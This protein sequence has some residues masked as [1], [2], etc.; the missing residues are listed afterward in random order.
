MK[1]RSTEPEP[2]A[3]KKVVV[4]GLARQGMALARYLV[5]EGA[6]VTISDLRDAE[7]LR[8]ALGSLSDIP[9]H[10]V[11]GEHPFS[12]LSDADLVCLSG[13]VPVH[14]PIV[15]E[16]QRRGI[17]LSNDAQLFLERCSA[18]VV[19]ITGSSGKT[20][21]TALVGRMLQRD[22]FLTWVGGNIGRPLVDRL[23]EIREEDRVVM[24][25]SSFQL[26]VMSV[27][28]EVAAVLNVTPNHLDRH[29]TMA[30]YTAIK[31][32][33]LDFQG[34]NGLA[35]L[36]EDDEGSRR[37]ATA[38]RGRLA[39]F[40][41]QNQTTDDINANTGAYIR[42]RKLTVRLGDRE[43]AICLTDEVKLL[44]RHNLQNVLAACVLAA[45]VGVSIDVMRDV[46]TSFTGVEHRLQFVRTLNGVRYYDDSIATAPE[47]TVAALRAFDVPVVLLAGG[48][49]KS[50]PWDEMAQITL[51]RARHVV[52]FGEAAQ[53]VESEIHKA[54]R[55]Q[56]GAT[57]E[58]LT[59]VGT[60]EEAVDVA[61]RVARPGEVVLLSPGGTSFDAY[62]DFVERGHRFQALV[63]AL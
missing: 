45:A 60:L 29:R 31:K 20:T 23:W 47:R 56:P 33:I 13:G 26:E 3:G 19:G 63:Q 61:A 50:L 18:P 43:H 59:R 2:L 49:D 7:E 37:L 27:S 8:E 44:G 42:D 10:F 38:V 12:I 52:A 40:S 53:L 51:Q 25:L 11:L 4:L 32:R 24:E 46:A 15:V 57:L 17:P 48:K 36:S 5:R 21:T 41:A 1:R 22:R 34:S 9:A 28:P 58:G 35:V 14:A 55:T 54:E 6:T 62:R 16:A 30:A 39:F